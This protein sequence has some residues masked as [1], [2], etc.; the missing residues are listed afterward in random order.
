MKGRRWRP[1]RTPAKSMSSFQAPRLPL[2]AQRVGKRS[3]VADLLPG[4]AAPRAGGR[5]DRESEGLLFLTNDGES[6]CVSPIPVSGSIKLPGHRRGPRRAR[7]V[8][9]LTEGIEDCGDRL[10][11]ERARIL[12]A[13]I[14]ERDR[15]RTGRKAKN[16]SPAACSAI[17]LN[18]AR[19]R[20]IQ[21]D[22]SNWANCHP[23]N[24]E[25]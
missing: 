18:V 6:P 17:D 5:L 25:R 24:G 16:A 20:R 2:H 21:I 1:V 13:T 4:M 11:A 10:K 15:T 23:A 7:A 14:P 3:T 22:V 12:S 8:A 9:R 19:L